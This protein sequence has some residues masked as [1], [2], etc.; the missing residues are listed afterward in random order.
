MERKCVKFCLWSSNKPY[1]SEKL[2]HPWWILYTKNVQP[3][4]FFINIILNLWC[5][6]WNNPWIENVT[7]K[8]LLFFFHSLCF[9]SSWLIRLGFGEI[10]SNNKNTVEL[11]TFVII[12]LMNT[13]I[14][15]SISITIP[16]I[17][18]EKPVSWFHIVISFS[19]KPNTKS[20]YKITSIVFWWINWRW[21]PTSWSILKIARCNFLPYDFLTNLHPHM[22][23]FQ[24]HTYHYRGVQNQVICD[25]LSH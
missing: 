2:K 1:L 15:V 19:Y 18:C 20:N 12:I 9:C 22:L 5:I 17:W 11:T 10:T 8:D 21:L 14:Q 24:L 16:S 6:K 23:Y 4:Y 7:N 3:L 13:H 25:F